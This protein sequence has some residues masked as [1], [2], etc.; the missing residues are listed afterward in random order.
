ME[1]NIWTKFWHI[2]IILQVTSKIR[3]TVFV[4]KNWQ[5]VWA[6]NHKTWNDYSNPTFF[7][8]FIETPV[9]NHS[10]NRQRG[11]S[12]F[13]WEKY[14]KLL[15]SIF[16]CPSL[17]QTYDILLSVRLSCRIYVHVCPFPMSFINSSCSKCLFMKF[18][19]FYN[20]DDLFWFWWSLFQNFE[21]YVILFTEFMFPV[22][23]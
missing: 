9:R 8:I 14:K 18:K 21:S 15:M 1:S 12:I 6:S 22:I 4:E 3:I 13:D 19:N 20:E 11:K 10:F 23:Q 5:D 2:C 17:E 16:I 7:A